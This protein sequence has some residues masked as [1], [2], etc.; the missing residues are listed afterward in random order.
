MLAPFAA[1]PLAA[2]DLR[3]IQLGLALI[4]DYNGMLNGQWGSASVSALTQFSEREFDDIPCLAN[5][6]LGRPGHLYRNRRGG[7]RW[8]EHRDNHKSRPVDTF[9]GEKAQLGPDSP[10][11]TS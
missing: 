7:H 8:L 6:A 2:E 10:N 1:Q 3:M 5:A 11:F 4:H 9:P